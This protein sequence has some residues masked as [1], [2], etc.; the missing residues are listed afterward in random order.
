MT[1]AEAVRDGEVIVLAVPWSSIEE[2]HRGV[3]RPQPGAR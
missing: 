1:V 2:T 3:R